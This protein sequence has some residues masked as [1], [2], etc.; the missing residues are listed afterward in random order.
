M[1][2]E[3]DVNSYTYVIYQVRNTNKLD[4][5]FKQSAKDIIL[6]LCKRTCYVLYESRFR[7]YKYLLISIK[8]SLNI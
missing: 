7:V 5:R 6:V 2:D 3:D 4:M 8:Y 1:S